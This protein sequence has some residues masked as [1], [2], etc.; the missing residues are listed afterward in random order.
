[1]SENDRVAEIRA[2][3]A[4]ATR[5]PWRWWGNVDTRSIQLTTR[6]RGVLTIMAFKRWGMQGA[7]P[8]FFRR[9]PDMPYGWNG[10]QESAEDIAVREVPY[11]GDIVEL[12]NPNAK[13]IAN[14]PADIAWLLEE[15]ERLIAELNTARAQAAR[16]QAHEFAGFGFG[17]VSS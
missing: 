3:L 6:D 2:R 12:D 4:A 17:E 16:A 10:V 11:R 8:A 5:G 7:A 9:T 14:A 1:V 13:L 15:R